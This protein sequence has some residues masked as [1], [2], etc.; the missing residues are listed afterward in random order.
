V[1]LTAVNGITNAAD[2]LLFS[3]GDMTLR[4][5]GFSNLYGDVYSKGNLSFAAQD[6]GR[7]VLFSNRSG[8]VESEGSIGIN[9]GFIEN[10][11]DA[12]ELGQTLTT[13]SLSWICGQHCGE[14]DNWEKGLITIY[15]TYLEAATKD[16]VAARLV[17]GK[18]MLLQG[19]NVQNRYSL[20]AANG[21][22]SITAGDLL[23]QGA[24]TRTGQ[25]K[26]VVSTPGRISDDLF[27]SMQYVD[28]P[29][30]NA[31]TAAGHFDKA[32]F[33]EL[34][35]RSPNSFPFA[36]ISDVTTWTPNAGHEY[37]ATLQAGGTVDLSKVTRKRK[38]ARCTKTPWRN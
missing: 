7:A 2:S 21:D 32:R 34:K 27:E 10:A 22:L 19:D 14:K 18:N 35:N 17:A 38:T 37:D 26:I 31:A 11:K 33:E 24:A 6:G 20:M 29:A 12:F 5:N 9:A 3:G 8:T 25:R 13:G 1:N 28:V 30:F 4:S 36:Y 16:S 15:E 23:N